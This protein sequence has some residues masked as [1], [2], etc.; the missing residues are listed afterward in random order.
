MVAL[1][2]QRGAKDYSPK[3]CD[4][5]LGDNRYPN[6]IHGSAAMPVA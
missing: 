5:V 3:G 6:D 4:H 1:K 2:P